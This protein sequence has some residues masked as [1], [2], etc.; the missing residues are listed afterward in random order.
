MVTKKQLFT[1]LCDA[2]IAPTDVVILHSSM[3]AFG[4]FE[5]GIEGLVDAFCEYLADGL[6]IVPTHSW[7]TVNKKNPV[8]D[9]E[10]TQSCVGLLSRVALGKKEGVRSKHP[11]HSVVAFGKGAADFTAGEE[12]L[13]TPTPRNGVYGKLIDRDAVV[14]LLG[15]GQNKNTFLHC[16]EETANVPFE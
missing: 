14:L 1:D 16:L 10:K 11:T 3:K 13:I 9:V 6:F 7:A 12:K 2:G 4:R 15:V 8:F 5:E